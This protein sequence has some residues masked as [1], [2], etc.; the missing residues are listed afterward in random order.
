MKDARD[1]TMKDGKSATRG[2]CPVSGTE[3]FR[4]GNSW[5]QHNQGSTDGLMSKRFI[6]S[7]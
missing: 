1:I 6:V 4:I 3:I 5:R 2:T 7:I